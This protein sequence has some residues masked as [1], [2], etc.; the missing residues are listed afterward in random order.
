MVAS[1][2]SP[3]HHR[4]QLFSKREG[5]LSSLFLFFNRYR[6]FLSCLAADTSIT[7]DYSHMVIVIIGTRSILA[8]CRNH[9]NKRDLMTT[10]T[11]PWRSEYGKIVLVD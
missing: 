10:H 4:N 3:L 7:Y 8:D 1:F 5:K 2:Q 11:V 6:L 9:G